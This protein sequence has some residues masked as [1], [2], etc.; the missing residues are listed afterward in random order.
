MTTKKTATKAAK[1]TA[2][3]AKKT[4]KRAIG[5]AKPRSRRRS[6]GDIQAAN[7]RGAVRSA[8]QGG[9]LQKAAYRVPFMVRAADIAN[10][11]EEQ[12]KEFVKALIRCERNDTSFTSGEATFGDEMKAADQGADAVTTYFCTSVP[13]SSSRASKLIPEGVAIWQLKA[14]KRAPTLEQIRREIKKSAVQKAL[15]INGS[16]ILVA[17]QPNTASGQV[18][19]REDLKKVA[20]TERAVFVGQSS[21]EEHARRYPSIARLVA[22]LTG[23]ADAF[24][25]MKAGIEWSKEYPHDTEFQASSGRT[26]QMRQIMEWLRAPS[27]TRASNIRVLGSPGIGK[28]RLVLE[29]LRIAEILPVV[30]YA[31]G[32]NA[33]PGGFLAQAASSDWECILVVDECRD[34]ELREL[35]SAFGHVFD[36]VRLISIGHIEDETE[37]TYGPETTVIAVKRLDSPSV[38]RVLLAK[39]P[40]MPPE[41]AAW[42]ALKTG[43]Y[44]KLALLLADAIASADNERLERLDEKRLVSDYLRVV[45]RGD[46]SLKLFKMMALFTRV[47]FSGEV[48]QQFEYV[49]R[50][51]GVSRVD[52]DFVRGEAERRGFVSRAE[53]YCYVTPELLQDW[54]VT[55]LLRDSFDA[56]LRMLQGAP[57]ELLNLAAPRLNRFVDE[58]VQRAQHLVGQLVLDSPTFAE[59]RSLENEHVARAVCRLARVATSSTAA[60]VERWGRLVEINDVPVSVRRALV[61]LLLELLW[62]PDWFRFAFEQMLRLACDEAE[63]GVANNATGSIEA[64]FLIHLAPTQVSYVE[65]VETAREFFA[66][67]VVPVRRLLVNAVASGLEIRETGIVSPL[68]RDL[69]KSWRP[70]SLGEKLAAKREALDFVSA[71]LADDDSSIRGNAAK[72]IVQNFRSLLW[73][74]LHVE[75]LNALR[76]VGLGLPIVREELEHAIAWDAKRVTPEAMEDVKRLYAELPSDLL[77]EVRFAT[78]GWDLLENEHSEFG[79]RQR[80]G[81]AELA[82]RVLVSDLGDQVVSILLSEQAQNSGPFAYELGRADVGRNLWGSVMRQR[83]NSRAAWVASI[84]LS[85]NLHSRS[86]EQEFLLS[87]LSSGD[88]FFVEVGSRTLPGIE[89]SRAILEDVGERIRRHQIAPSW[90]A[91]IQLGGWTSRVDKVGLTVLMRALLEH[92]S[93]GVEVALDA[94]RMAIHGKVSLDSDLLLELTERG[95]GVPRHSSHQWAKV[96]RAALPKRAFEIGAML[97]DNVNK[98]DWIAFD[99][100]AVEVFKECIVAVGSKLAMRSLGHAVVGEE[101]NPRVVRLL[102]PEV[103]EALGVDAVLEWA[104]NKGKPAQAVL[105]MIVPTAPLPMV[106]AMFERFGASSTFASAFSAE[107]LSGTFWGPVSEHYAKQAHALEGWASEQTFPKQFRS[108]AAMLAARLRRNEVREREDERKKAELEKLDER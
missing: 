56:T 24:G 74:G 101:Y 81:L 60:L 85:G 20:K 87:L 26:E 48:A 99:D 7:Q 98:H 106:L 11:P 3:A 1:K 91:G 28:T 66:R 88:R 17:Q 14:E 45:L 31:P 73:V 61:Y 43:G 34:A 46:E 12:F 53:P 94:A 36:R 19:V 33:I 63:P 67:G 86:Q 58:G 9:G 21:L 90:L 71:A 50:R 32:K 62:H 79:L 107:F 82:R 40:S 64:V 97:L 70:R 93:E 47:G 59:I 76:L 96:A 4:A 100:E 16:Y 108:W 102:G 75:A 37:G 57:P 5:K 52:A 39:H 18:R 38:E 51:L 54:L 42:V 6:R 95:L 80:P 78:G 25:S 29:A 35:V 8:S 84:Y 92:S 55:V 30:L 83:G 69:R 89:P 23:S 10:L 104:Q 41:R 44:V 103:V 72:Q 77:T 68:G 15:K 2:K 105:A 22:A 49:A 27:T 13:P 65:R